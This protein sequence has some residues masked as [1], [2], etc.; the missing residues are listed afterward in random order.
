MTTTLENLGITYKTDTEGNR[1]LTLPDEAHARVLRF[2]AETSVKSTADIAAAAQ[3]GHDSILAGIDGLSDAQA[4]W[5][6]AP[7]VWCALQLM[8]HVVTVKRIMPVLS[9]A[10]GSG[11]LPP[12]FGPQFEEAKAQDG[13]TAA[14]F[15]TIAEAR[16]AAEA[17]HR[18]MLDVIGGLDDAATELKFSHFVFGSMNAR[19]WACFY[20]VH[21]A[22]HGPALFRL[23]DLPGFPK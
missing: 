16:D 11:A 7:D 15:G 13:V 12:G 6:P 19:E 17:A 18:D 22:D 21:D 4:A 10:L 2:I 20:R 1:L 3:E 9:R 5:K 8:A 23:R 14:S